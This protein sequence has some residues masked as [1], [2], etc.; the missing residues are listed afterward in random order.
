MEDT[1][2]RELLRPAPSNPGDWAATASAAP[3]K[4]NPTD[5]AAT[6]FAAPVQ[7]VVPAPRCFPVATCTIQAIASAIQEEA[8]HMSQ[9]ETCTWKP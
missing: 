6:P 2:M 7:A 8:A 9:G 4:E 3:V 1:K 5:W